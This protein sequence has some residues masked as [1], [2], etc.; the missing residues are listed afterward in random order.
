MYLSLIAGL[1]VLATP[2]AT[3]EATVRATLAAVSKADWQAA[4]SRVDNANVEAAVKAL[5]S[6]SGM[7]K[8][9]YEIVK[10][11]LVTKDDE[12]SGPIEW[13]LSGQLQN[14]VVRLRRTNG[15]WKILGGN[16]N[17]QSFFTQFAKIGRDPSV[18]KVA[19]AAADKTVVLSNMKQLAL[20]LAIFASD[21][22]DKIAVTQAT[23]KSSLL[24]IVKSDRLWIDSK[25]E[26]L[27][28][29][30]NPNLIGKKVTAFSNPE[31]VVMLT[32]GPK[33]GLK[34]WDDATPVAFLDGHVKFIKRSATAQLRWK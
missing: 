1:V 30:I 28:V 9:D 31:S 7:S 18:L 25:N 33:D 34:F 29:R 12:S 14:D 2:D 10:L 15:D 26:P 19:R 8:F 5:R 20:G 3:P 23:L 11:D 4:F 16:D 6:M 21:R 13:K 22:N 32:I 27:D 24:P 17:D